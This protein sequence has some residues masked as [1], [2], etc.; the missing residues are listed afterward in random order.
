VPF[1]TR[2]VAASYCVAFGGL[3]ALASVGSSN[4]KELVFLS[5][6]TT[7][8]SGM[9]RALTDAFAK[10]SNLAVKSIVGGS[11]Q[12]LKQGSRGEGDVLLTHSPEA[13]KAWMAEGNGTSRRL[14]MYRDMVVI[15]PANDPAKIR[16][17]G[18]AEAL[19]RISNNKAPFVSRGDQSGTHMRELAMWRQAGIEPRGQSW[20]HETGRGQG[21]T[22]EFASRLDAYTLTD[23][24][25]YQVL[26][27]VLVRRISL[28][29]LVQNDTG[30]YN[31]YHVM[32]VNGAK[33]PRVNQVAG[34][35][36]ADW[37]VSEEGQAVI[38]GFGKKEFG[39]S[40]FVPAADKREDELL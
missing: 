1:F 13:E 12:I 15:G 19:R 4:S 20:Y 3:V 32:P 14:V 31:I 5:T 29:I 17:L 6:P 36:F 22:M 10:K 24:A 35:A 30:L 23:R 40:M 26:A 27:L 21:L 7:R 39:R 28:R 25:T 9:L 2:L 34:Q 18:I 33:F 37:I 16:G 38:S 11:D 8:D